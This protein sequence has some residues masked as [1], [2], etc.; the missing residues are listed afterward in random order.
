MAKVFS[1]VNIFKFYK[2]IAFFKPSECSAF[3]ASDVH[4][5]SLTPDTFL[6]PPL[7]LWARCFSWMLFQ[8]LE[9]WSSRLHHFSILVSL[10]IMMFVRKREVS[11]FMSMAM[12]V[13]IL[14]LLVGIMTKTCWVMRKEL[15][16]QI[17]VIYF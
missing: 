7:V 1:K 4:A 9:L 12:R 13:E 11:N 15:S 16:K 2:L 10:V 17:C 3:A 8:Q 14:F 5:L 6:K